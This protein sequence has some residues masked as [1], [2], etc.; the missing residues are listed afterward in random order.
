MTPKELIDAAIAPLS[1]VLREA[2]FKKSG[3]R[4]KR[5]VGEVRLF[6]D[7][8]ASQ[9]NRDQSASF[10]INLAVFAPSVLRKL[11]EDVG[12]APNSEAGC[13][14]LDRIGFLTPEKKDLWWK[15]DSAES[16]KDVSSRVLET[17]HRYAIPWLVGAETYEGL[18]DILA[19]ATGIPAA[20]ILWS[21]G[22]HAEARACVKRMPLN[23]SGRI[24]AAAE[25]V[26][27]HE[28]AL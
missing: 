24:K 16:V 13:T 2:G 19:Q 23:T 27:L 20:D 11:G 10:T 17:V 5:D 12:D 1:T 14:W 25:W 22:L 3:R 26:Q 18:C 4:F 6:L 21:L 9:W 8:Q 15:L 7:V 28:E